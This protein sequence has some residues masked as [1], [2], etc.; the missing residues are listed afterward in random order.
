[1]TANGDAPAPG[2]EPGAAVRLVRFRPEH[3]PEL[4]TWVQSIEEATRWASLDHLPTLE[5]LERWHAQPYATPF[6]LVEGEDAVGYGEVWDDGEEDRAVDEAELARLVVKP[7]ERGRGLGRALTRALA[8]EAWRLGVAEVWL[9]VVE[10]NMP[11]RR[12]YE[13]AGF[14]RATPE[15]EAAFNAG[16]RRVYAWMRDGLDGGGVK[17]Q[18]P[19]R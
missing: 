14:V 16:Q 6:V 11:A 8:D 9:R 17:A 5:D 12:A 19:V 15:E 7:A 1:M 2:S 3:G 18:P 10:D 13:A 4:T